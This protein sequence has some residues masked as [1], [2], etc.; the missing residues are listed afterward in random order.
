MKFIEILKEIHGDSWRFFRFA[1]ANGPYSMAWAPKMPPWCI[2]PVRSL[3]IGAS[4]HL[5]A[6]SRPV[7]AQKNFSPAPYV[8]MYLK[9][10]DALTSSRLK[11]QRRGLKGGFRLENGR[12]RRVLGPFRGSP[13]WRASLGRP[14]SVPRTAR[15]TARTRRRC[16][17]RPKQTRARRGLEGALLRPFSGART[18]EDVVKTGR[19]GRFRS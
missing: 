10:L 16:A 9:P 6:L 18:G 7:R 14:W 11:N 1:T 5:K 4:S 12:K 3:G 17:P 13:A 15:A 2:S 19:N 8:K